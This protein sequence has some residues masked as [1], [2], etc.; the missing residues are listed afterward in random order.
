[1][2]NIAGLKMKIET[3]QIIH[4]PTVDSPFLVLFKPAGIPSAPLFEGDSSILTAAIDSFP[5]IALV[6]GRKEVEHGLVHRIDTE[7][8]GLVLIATTQQSYDSLILAQKNGLFEKW[9]HAEIDE[10]SDCGE[11]LASFPPLPSSLIKKISDSKNKKINF[12]LSSSF[13][14]FG[15]NGRE[16]R[17]VTEFSGKAALKKAGSQLYNTEISI[18]LEHDTALCH[19]SAGFRHQVRCHLA[20]CGFPVKED[21][22]YNPNA[23]KDGIF[24]GKENSE[25]HDMKFCA[26]KISF[27]HPL[28][29][30]PQ[31]FQM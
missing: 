14:P 18:D 25:R 4:F 19:I 31:V 15:K 22:I 29:Q 7:T 13:R 24:L 9:Y 8:K 10:L 27:P 2:K 11:K 16:V 3:S 23:R 5:E 28:S 12:M 30:I 21:L 6:H 1:M 26:C 20:W 17:P